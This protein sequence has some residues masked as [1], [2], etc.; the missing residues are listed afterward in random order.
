[1]SFLDI[2]FRPKTKSLLACYEETALIIESFAE[3]R[4]EKWDWDDFTSIKKK[5]AYLESIRLQCISVSDDYPTKEEG[6][7]CSAAGV[8]VLRALARD[9][10]QR[11]PSIQNETGA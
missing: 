8:D 4:S 11:I 10:R 1:M 9:V 2:I 5:D 6:R 7:Y 3:G